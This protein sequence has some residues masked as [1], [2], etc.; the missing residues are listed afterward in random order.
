MPQRLTSLGGS[1]D[2]DAKPLVDFELPD[3]VA[4]ALRAKVAVF[5][6][7]GNGGLEDGFARHGGKYSGFTAR[8]AGE[9]ST[10]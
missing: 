9:K 7:G 1:I 3:H 2:R 10:V 6:D 8:R 5:V 4:H